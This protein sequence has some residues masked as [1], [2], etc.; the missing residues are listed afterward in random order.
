[1]KSD[2]NQDYSKEIKKIEKSTL[3]EIKVTHI[4][5]VSVWIKSTSINP[6]MMDKR[7]NKCNLIWEYSNPV[8][9]YSYIDSYFKRMDKSGDND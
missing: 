5:N 9:S 4:N 6:H 1:M 3:Q 8:E 2:N 7:K